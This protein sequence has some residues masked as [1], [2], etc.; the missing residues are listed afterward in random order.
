MKFPLVIVPY[1]TQ[2]QFINKRYYAF[3]ISIIITI[4]VFALL[5]FRGLNLGIDFTGGIIIDLKA[6]ESIELQTIRESLSSCGYHN[7]NIQN[8]EDNGIIIRIQPKGNKNYA[9]EIEQLK[10]ELDQK[11]G[12]EIDFRKIDYV[13][14][15]ISED[16][17][18]KAITAIL[19]SL[20]IMMLYVTARFNW[21]FGIGIV[22]ALIH[23]MIA[24]VGFY[25]VSG[26]EFDLTSIAAILTIIGYSVNDSVV[27]Y[28]RIRENMH[29]YK[30]KK[31]SDLI[32]ISINETLSRTTMTVTTTLV[33]CLALVLFGGPVLKGF[34]TAVLFG[35][36]FGT[37]SSIYI[38]APILLLL[39]KN[40]K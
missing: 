25:I 36:A 21:Q 19:I 15:K 29:K 4:S 10:S 6:P 34:S 39:S 7:A 27:I 17:S 11:M 14:P 24:T 40:L 32:N 30:N 20:I 3:A 16:L 2:I 12:K 9:K 1:N 13:G 23:D 38:S 33:V 28:D 35:I 8:Y 26:Y 5:F 31:N 18:R 37:Y 22:I